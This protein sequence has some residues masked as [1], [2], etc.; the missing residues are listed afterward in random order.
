M[1]N[2]TERPSSSRT[3]ETVGGHEIPD[4]EPRYFVRAITALNISST[5]VRNH[6][7]EYA[8]FLSDSANPQK[9]ETRQFTEH[10]FAKLQTVAILRNQYRSLDEIRE[11]LER[12]E[13]LEPKEG[14]N[15]PK[16]PKNEDKSDQTS[17]LVTD[18]EIRLM[19]QIADIQHERGVAVGKLETAEIELKAEREAHSQTRERLLSAETEK[20][21]AIGRLEEIENQRTQ[22]AQQ[23]PESADFRPNYALWGV[24]TLLFI[25]V[26][27]LIVVAVQA[28]GS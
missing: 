22:L 21:K 16:E 13:L 20:A 28:F 1:A 25:V 18:R 14:S 12:G 5:S 17:S 7:R 24:G 26:V 19:R 9:G 2:L 8:E 11:F 10:D 15:P 6:A 3:T 27:V 4:H 23:E